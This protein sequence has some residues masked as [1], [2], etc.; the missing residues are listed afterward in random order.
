MLWRWNTYRIYTS[1]QT[2]EKHADLLLLS[3]FENPHYPLIK[4]FS[5]KIDLW[6]IKQNVIVKKIFCWYCL[7]SFSDSRVLECHIKICRTFD[8]TKPVLLPEEDEYV[9]VKD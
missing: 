3:N 2:F 7:Q 9:N 8:Y 5:F 1:E 6:R 4:S